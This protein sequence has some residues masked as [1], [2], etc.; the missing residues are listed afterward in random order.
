MHC[1]NG[2]QIDSEVA[3]VILIDDTTEDNLLKLNV[4]D[5]EQNEVWLKKIDWLIFIKNF[6]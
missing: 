2:P 5:Y 4:L 3:I 1:I 6:C